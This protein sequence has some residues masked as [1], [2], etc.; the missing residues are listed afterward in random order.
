MTAMVQMTA[1]NRL[2]TP[3][4]MVILFYPL[5]CVFDLDRLMAYSYMSDDSD[6]NQDLNPRYV[7]MDEW[8]MRKIS[9]KRIFTFVA[10]L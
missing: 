2:V 5:Y 9:R 1:R 10:T 7:S 8:L 6:F 3:G 4:K